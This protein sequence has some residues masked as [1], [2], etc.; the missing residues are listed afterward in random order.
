[1]ATITCHPNEFLLTLC[2]YV[3]SIFCNKAFKVLDLQFKIRLFC[4][5]IK[6]KSFV[7][8]PRV[9]P[10]WCIIFP[11]K[12]WNNKLLE[13]M[14]HRFLMFFSGPTVNQCIRFNYITILQFL[15]NLIM[16]RLNPLT[17]WLLYNLTDSSALVTP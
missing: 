2:E 5:P 15:N 3:H 7:F 17:R 1:M 6:C 12:I 14:I 8:S 10:Q 9:M 13:S 16:K 4:K 11:L